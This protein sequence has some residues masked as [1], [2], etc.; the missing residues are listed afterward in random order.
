MKVTIEGTPEEIGKMLLWPSVPGQYT[1]IPTMKG[2][3]ETRRQV[4]RHPE[5]PYSKEDLAG[6]WL[7]ENGL[8]IPLLNSLAQ[9]LS[10][11]EERGPTVTYRATGAMTSSGV[12]IKTLTVT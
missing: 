4:L 3:H 10:K 2:I 12:D 6:L 9:L 5:E 11:V 8:P 1:F 7:Q